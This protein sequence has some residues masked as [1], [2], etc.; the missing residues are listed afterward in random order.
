MSVLRKAN[1]FPS[2]FFLNLYGE[3]PL[4]E[5]IPDAKAGS[6]ANLTPVQIVSFQYG[7]I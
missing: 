4:K 2:I 1:R 5:L 6:K 3:I 7:M